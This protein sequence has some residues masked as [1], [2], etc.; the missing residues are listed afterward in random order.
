M[1]DVIG[2][3]YEATHVVCMLHVFRFLLK[4]FTLVMSEKNEPSS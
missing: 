3:A 2:E 1:F 4:F